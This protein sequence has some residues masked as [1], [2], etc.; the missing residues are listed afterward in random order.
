MENLLRV[1]NRS[2]KILPLKISLKEVAMLSMST[3]A[4]LKQEMR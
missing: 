3:G 4:S 2:E 1:E